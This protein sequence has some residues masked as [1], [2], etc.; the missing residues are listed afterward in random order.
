[1]K[2]ILMGL[3]VS[4]LLAACGQQPA[5]EAPKQ[6][7]ASEAALVKSAICGPSMDIT[8]EQ[9]LTNLDQGLRATG[10]SPA[11]LDKKLSSNDCGYLLEMDMDY[12]KI[13]MEIDDQKRVRNLGVGYENLIGQ[14]HMLKNATNAFASIQTA[15]SAT[16]STKWGETELGK[17]LFKTLGDLVIEHKNAGSDTKQLDVDGKRYIVGV[18][19][20]AVLVIVQALP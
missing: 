8:M 18:E 20:A 6:I 2:K 19:G 14:E 1:M 9:L 4:L 12:G 10:A 5:A 17:T 11:V 16:G 3:S 15:M 7:S 13:R